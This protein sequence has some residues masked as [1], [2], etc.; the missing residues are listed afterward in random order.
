[1]FGKVRIAVLS[2]STLIILYGLVGGYMDPVSARDEA[3]RDLSVFTDV[4]NKVRTEYVETPDMEKTLRGALHGMIEA[5]DGYSSFVEAETYRTLASRESDVASPG[6]ILSKRYGYVYVVSVRPEGSAAREGLRTGDLLESIESNVTTQMSLWEARNLMKGEPG[7]EVRVRVIRFRRS[8]PQELTLQR[9]VLAAQDVS[10]RMLDDG[11]GLLRIPE[12]REGVTES[13]RAKLKMLNSAG[14]NGLLLDVRGTAS[15]D[16]EEAVRMAELFLEEGAVVG[17]SRDR[18]G[19]Q[20]EFVAKGPSLLTGIPVI[21]LID[22]GSSGPAEMLAAAVKENGVAEVVGE[23]SNGHG[24]LQN[25]FDLSDGSVLFL[26]TRMFH[27]PGG[28][29]IQGGELRTSGIEPDL[30]VPA[31]EFVTNFYFENT[32]DEDEGELAEEFY[33]KLDRAIEKEQLGA[34]VER[35]QQRIQEKT[36]KEAA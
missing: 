1:M 19:R 24:S 13:V 30:R 20:E 25:R 31:P 6:L 9:T 4:I 8:E 10:A 3:Y 15:G 26:S 21:V 27:R 11:I 32:S 16:F 22:G 17:S 2:L 5:L 7:S 28:A 14:L 33:L 34:A 23:R 36:L 35:L 12:L 29:P 18:M